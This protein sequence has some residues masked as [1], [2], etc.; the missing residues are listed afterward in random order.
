MLLFFWYFKCIFQCLLWHSSHELILDWPKSS[1]G[2]FHMILQKN[3]N[4]HFVQPYIISSNIHDRFLTIIQLE[5]FD[6]KYFIPHGSL[7]YSA[8][9]CV[10][11]VKV[12]A[13]HALFIFFSL[14]F[15]LVFRYPMIDTV[16]QLHLYN[17]CGNGFVVL[18]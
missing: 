9:T 17:S 16:Q 7:E 1:F 11:Q 13:L 6:S 18:M 14:P 2:L 8:L 4:E 15:S 10:I 3:S 5:E 12:D